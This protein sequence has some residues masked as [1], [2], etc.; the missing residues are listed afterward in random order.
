MLLRFVL[1]SNTLRNNE[2][3]LKERRIDDKLDKHVTVDQWNKCIQVTRLIWVTLVCRHSHIL[4]HMVVPQCNVH[5]TD[6]EMGATGA[7]MGT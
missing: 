4:S 3:P 6:E 2:A 7:L 1:N 5:F